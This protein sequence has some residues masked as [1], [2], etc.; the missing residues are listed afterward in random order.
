MLLKYRFL[1]LA[2]VCVFTVSNT[3]WGSNHWQSI[4]ESDGKGYYAYLPATFIYSDPHFNFHDSIEKKYYS[5]QTFYDYRVKLENGTVNKYFIGTS[6]LQAP[7][8]FIAHAI[9][10]INGNE[11]DGY[12]YWYQI[13]I[14]IAGIF[15]FLLGMFLCER[16]LRLFF[17][18]EKTTQIITLLFSLGTNL[19]YYALFEPAMSHTY[20]FFCVALFLYSSLAFIRFKNARALMFAIISFALIVLIRPVNALILFSIPFLLGEKRFTDVLQALKKHTNIFIIASLIFTLII[21]LQPLYYYWQCKQWWVYAYLQEGFVWSKI[22]FHKFLFSYRKGFFVYTPLCLL[23]MCG[24]ILMFRRDLKQFIKI[25]FFLSMIIYVLSSWWMW[26]YGGG[27]GSRVMI[28]YLPFFMILAAYALNHLSPFPKKIFLIL[29]LLCV[30]LNQFQ[31]YQYR[32]LR[33]HWSEM[34]SEKYWESFTN[35]N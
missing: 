11:K 29:A 34:N 18:D 6:I 35:F 24:W 14:S 3:Q 20:S 15:Y 32:Y 22:N 30:L 12:S 8:F 4:I 17:Y 28:E 23:A 10:G 5:A 25:S 1:I 7:F 31:T 2:I 9:T 33:I 16:L 13:M 21:A 26:W 27:F 19:F